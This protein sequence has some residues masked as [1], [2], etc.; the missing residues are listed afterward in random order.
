VTLTTAGLESGGHVKALA[1]LAGDETTAKKQW[2]RLPHVLSG[3]LRRLAPALRKTGISVEFN[4]DN[5]SRT[6][7]VGAIP[8]RDAH[9]ARDARDASPTSTPSSYFQQKKKETS[10]NERHQASQRYQASPNGT[11]HNGRTRGDDT[12]LARL[13]EIAE[14]LGIA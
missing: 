1:E 13:E 3:Q 8:A 6:I 14:E 2:P 4:R 11:A 12:E 5:T 10:W 9:G 7:R